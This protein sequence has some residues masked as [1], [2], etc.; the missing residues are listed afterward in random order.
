MPLLKP[1]IAIEQL[2]QEQVKEVTSHMNEAIEKDKEFI[3]QAQEK[4]EQSTNTHWRLVN[5]IVGD[6]V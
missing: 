5:F 2:S 1:T 6:K 4:I 3:K